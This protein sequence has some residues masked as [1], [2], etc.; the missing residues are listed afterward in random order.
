MSTSRSHGRSHGRS[1]SSRSHGRW[2][3][4]PM[5]RARRRVLPASKQRC[6]PAAACL[7]LTARPLALALAL[8]LALVVRAALHFGL[9]QCLARGVTRPR[10]QRAVQQL[11][12]Q[13]QQIALFSPRLLQH[14][15]LR[16]PR[17]LLARSRRLPPRVLLRWRRRR[18]CARARSRGP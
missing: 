8:A 4:R 15:R 6:A 10:T 1:G 5:S 2:Y 9:P 17:R 18:T 16:P 11:L 3:L 7:H 12:Q 13:Q 14:L